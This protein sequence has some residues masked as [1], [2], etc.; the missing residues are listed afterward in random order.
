VLLNLAAAA[1][2]QVAAERMVDAG[3][4]KVEALD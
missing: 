2:H 4:L 1:V 3:A